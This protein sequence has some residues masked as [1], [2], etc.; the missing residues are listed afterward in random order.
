MHSSRQQRIVSLVT[1]SIVSICILISVCR[2]RVI[3]VLQCHKWL[4]LSTANLDNVHRLSLIN[5]AIGKGKCY[6]ALTATFFAPML[7]SSVVAAIG[8]CIIFP[9][10]TNPLRFDLL[11]FMLSDDGDGGLDLEKPV[12]K[13]A[14]PAHTLRL[15]VS[16]QWMFLSRSTKDGVILVNCN[17][18]SIYAVDVTRGLITPCGEICPGETLLSIQSDESDSFTSGVVM[19]SGSIVGLNIS[20]L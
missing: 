16:E 19:E 3:D 5:C 11:Y 14:L 6:D 17:G 20:E 4:V 18:G 10:S 15:D 7:H 12:W 13:L 1:L 2:D 9:S 8:L